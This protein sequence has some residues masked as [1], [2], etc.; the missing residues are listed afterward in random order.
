MGIKYLLFI[1]FAVEIF[2]IE[3]KAQHARS[4]FADFRIF[5]GQN[6]AYVGSGAKSA[7]VPHQR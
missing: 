2:L 4:G 5:N 6:I 7:C 3:L 1:D